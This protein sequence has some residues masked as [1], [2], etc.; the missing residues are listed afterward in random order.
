[1]KRIDDPE[2]QELSNFMGGGREM[3]S[4]SN[5]SIIFP[6]ENDPEMIVDVPIVAGQ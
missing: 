5:S 4:K 1:M 2:S 3:M 6:P